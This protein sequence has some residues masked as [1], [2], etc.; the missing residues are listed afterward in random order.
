MKEVLTLLAPMVVAA[1][2]VAILNRIWPRASAIRLILIA[3]LPL[4]LAAQGLFLVMVFRPSPDDY[5]GMVYATALLIGPIIALV[6]FA[7]SVV[8]ASMT[9]RLLRGGWT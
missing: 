2:L 4:P 1:I 8:G 3:S 6:A 9:L 5:E 7:L